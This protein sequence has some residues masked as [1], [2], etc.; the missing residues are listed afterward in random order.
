MVEVRHAALIGHRTTGLDAAPSAEVARLP[1]EMFTIDAGQVL[2]DRHEAARLAATWADV[3]VLDPS[4][5]PAVTYPQP[6]GLDLEQLAAVVA[7][8]AASPRLV[9]ASIA[10]FRPDL[11]VTAVHAGR[12]VALLESTL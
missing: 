3:D 2:D 9:G 7:P 4:A 1:A 12:L 6:G 11:D 10:D 5:L 8:L